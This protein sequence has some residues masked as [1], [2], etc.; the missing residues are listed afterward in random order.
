MIQPAITSMGVTNKLIWS[1]EDKAIPMH[2]FI[3][4][5]MANVTELTCSA[6]LYKATLA[7]LLKGTEEDMT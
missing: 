3:L 6:A 7:D 2:R 5:F 4:F 1:D